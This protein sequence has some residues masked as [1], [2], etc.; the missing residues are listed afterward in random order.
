MIINYIF[1]FVPILKQYA[2]FFILMFLTQSLSGVITFYIRGLGLIKDLS[3]SSVVASVITIV[4][5]ILFLAVFRLGLIGYFIANIVG[6]LYQCIFWLFVHMSCMILNWLKAFAK[7]K[8][9]C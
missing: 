8:M 4:G 5:N 2:A 6:P 1:C 9:K 3:I 7:R